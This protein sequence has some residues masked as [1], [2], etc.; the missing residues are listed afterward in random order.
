MVSGNSV[1]KSS[2]RAFFSTPFGKELI[3]SFAQEISQEGN[4]IQPMKPVFVE[5]VFMSNYANWALTI[6]LFIQ[7]ISLPPTHRKENLQYWEVFFH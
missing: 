1:F 4:I 5:Q 2:H 3:K 6:S 7:P